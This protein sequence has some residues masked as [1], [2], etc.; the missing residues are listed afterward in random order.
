ME[1]RCFAR[2]GV[3]WIALAMLSVTAASTLGDGYDTPNAAP[4]ATS[5]SDPFAAQPPTLT[6]QAEDD[7]RVTL[8]LSDGSSLVGGLVGTETLVMKAI[9]GEVTI[10]VDKASQ[11]LIAPDGKR[12]VV[13]LQNGD[14]LTGEL[15]LDPVRLKTAWGEVSVN[16][17]HVV[18]IVRGTSPR[19]VCRRS[20]ETLPDGTTRHFDYYQPVPPSCPSPFSTPSCPAPTGPGPYSAPSTGANPPTVPPPSTSPYYSPAPSQPYGSPPF[21]AQVVPLAD[22]PPVVSPNPAE[23]EAGGLR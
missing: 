16:P 7:G 13:N 22:P 9:V 11:I 15:R 10:P 4:P 6:P 19:M 23:N 17:Q 21:Q 1:R 3:C 20:V 18:A 8:Q 2:C 5:Y 14:R 12:A